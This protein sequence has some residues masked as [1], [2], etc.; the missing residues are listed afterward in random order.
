MKLQ[1]T[2]LQNTGQSKVKCVLC[3]DQTEHVWV[4][5]ECPVT[6]T[7]YPDMFKEFIIPVLKKENPDNTLY[8]Q[9]RAP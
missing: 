7:V 9:H 5:G 1:T 4:F 2:Q 6:D 8:Q 3:F